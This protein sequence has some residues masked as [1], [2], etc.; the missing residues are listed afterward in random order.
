MADP[1]SWIGLEELGGEDFTTT[2][3]LGKWLDSFTDSEISGL[4][5]G[6][7]WDLRTGSERWVERTNTFWIRAFAV[8]YRSTPGVYT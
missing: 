8:K 7:K 6:Q 1:K 5:T 4:G 3:G 2:G